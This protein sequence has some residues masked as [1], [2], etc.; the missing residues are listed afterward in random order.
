VDDV[1]DRADWEALRAAGTEQAAPAGQVLVR[2]GSS[3]GSLFVV[4]A[5]RI[6]ISW[7]AHHGA[8]P[9]LAAR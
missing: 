4:L 1:L 6:A 8:R 5:G 3:G 7:A 2:E 9:G